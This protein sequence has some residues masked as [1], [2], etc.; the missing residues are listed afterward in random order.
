MKTLPDPVEHC[1]VC[2]WSLECQQERRRADDLS[3]VAGITGAPAARRCASTGV[4]T[5][6]GLAGVAP[7]DPLKIDG[8]RPETPRARP[9][10]RRASRSRARRQGKVLYELLDPEP[11][12]DG[13]LEPNLGLLA[14]PE[15]SPGDLFLDIEGDPFAFD[16]GIDY[17][18]GVLEP[19]L[20]DADG[21]PDV[22]SPSGRATP[23]AASAWPRRSAPS[24]S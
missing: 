2:R 1:D 5:R 24:R 17:L 8:T 4:T 21:Q 9:T 20:P 22:P 7:A 15:P 13:T 12:E 23:T 11:L 6:R 16:D 3:L 10:S 19:G 14:L 18:F